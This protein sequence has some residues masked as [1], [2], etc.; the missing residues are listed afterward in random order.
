MPQSDMQG[1]IKWFLSVIKQRPG[2][3]CLWLEQAIDSLLEYPLWLP[4]YGLEYEDVVHYG[5]ILQLIVLFLKWLF[6]N[7]SHPL[8]HQPVIDGI[9][10]DIHQLVQVL[11]SPKLVPEP[12]SIMPD[13]H[14]LVFQLG[15]LYNDVKVLYQCKG[16][17]DGLISMLR[18]VRDSINQL[19][20]VLL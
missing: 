14:G 1:M 10:G 7:P 5:I 6:D 17:Q 15:N 18:G 19:H 13:P 11:S 3:F 2:I 12:T 4:D 20:Q 9:T 16:G 8:H